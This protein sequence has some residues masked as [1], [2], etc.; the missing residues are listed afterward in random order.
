MCI[1]QYLTGKEK[2]EMKK[3]IALQEVRIK[4]EDYHKSDRR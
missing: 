4:K 1:A 2:Q 3:I